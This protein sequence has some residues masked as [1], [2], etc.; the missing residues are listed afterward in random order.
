MAEGMGIESLDKGD[1]MSEHVDW[2]AKERRIVKQSCL[3]CGTEIVVNLPELF[4]EEIITVNLPERKDRS[5]EGISE[6]IILVAERLYNW[7]YDEKVTPTPTLQ[8][9][10]LIEAVAKKLGIDAKEIKEIP[11]NQAEARLLYEKLKPRK[12]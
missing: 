11:H 9:K 6:L 3:K 1:T 12:S 8:Q 2:D 4:E 7:V 5:I 10:K